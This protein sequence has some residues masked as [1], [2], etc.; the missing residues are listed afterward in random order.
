V[1]KIGYNK[2]LIIIAIAA[3]A[4]NAVYFASPARSQQGTYFSDEFNMGAYNWT[5]VRGNWAVVNGQFTELTKPDTDISWASAGSLSWT[6]YAVE[7]KVYSNDRTGKF[8]IAG[9]WQDEN[10]HYGLEYSCDETGAAGANSARFV[11]YSKKNGVRYNLLTMERATNPKVP[12]I[13]EDAATVPNNPYPAV[14]K[15]KFKGSNIEIYCNN[16]LI[17]FTADTSVNYGK[18]ALGEF[19]RQVYFDDIFVWDVTPPVILSVTEKEI[20]GTAATI[21]FSTSESTSYRIDYGLTEAYGFY[22]TQTARDFKHEVDLTGLSLNTQYHYRIAVTDAAGNT[23]VSADRVFTTAAELDTVAPSVYNVSAGDI[24]ADTVTIYW[25]TSEP[26]NSIVDY[27]TEPGVYKWSISY[28]ARTTSHAV[29]LKRLENLTTYYFR[30]KSRDLSGNLGISGEYSF[31]T[32]NDLRP[33]IT[34]VKTGS[35]PTVNLSVYWKDVPEAVS[36]IVYVSTSNDWGAPVA[37]IADEA[38]KTQ[39]TYYQGSLTAYTNYFV[40]VYAINGSGQM[41]YSTIR[42]F[43]P[44]NNPH[45]NPH[46]YYQDNPELCGNC[47]YTHSA[48]GPKLIKEVNADR[49]CITCHDGTQS[50]YD[51]INGKVLGPTS[52]QTKDSNGVWTDVYRTTWYTSIAGPYGSIGG[53]TVAGSAY[54]PTS[55]HDLNIYNYAAPGNNIQ[56]VEVADAN[57]SCSSCHDPHGSDNYR[58]LRTNMN[59]L[60]TDNPP[61]ITVEA[62]AV[63]DPVNKRE[64]TVYVRG[65]VEFCGACHSDFNQGAGASRN[66]ISTTQQ[67]GMTLSNA[68]VHMYMHPVNVSAQ[69]VTKTAYA[70]PIPDYL[71]Y[72]NG[73]IICQTCHYTHGTTNAGNHIRRDGFESTCLKRFDKTTGCEDCHDKTNHPD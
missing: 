38:G 69:Y 5:S 61:L 59:V 44:G 46:G 57:L 51:V 26:G 58:N 28:D 11:L 23:A 62:Y 16:E 41:G 10:N 19:N 40:R 17:G 21:S 14:I 47:H 65:A 54:I 33:K 43:P 64:K 53:A 37:T 31:T 3:V 9:R 63:T 35:T 20:A 60:N 68:S 39:Y 48:L 4:V 42:A 25:N 30:V 12:Y 2:V 8:Y 71:P 18:I 6:D 22:K 66:A 15:V 49:L 67:P 72:E 73:K 34:A 29:Y 1:R 45:G 70:V 36:Y 32:L 7:A 52:D 27:G 13:G 24:A 55:R 56:N 50:K